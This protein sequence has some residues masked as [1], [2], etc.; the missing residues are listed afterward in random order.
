MD[1]PVG[2]S[3]SKQT[4]KSQKGSSPDNGERQGYHA[5]DVPPVGR[6]ARYSTIGLAEKL[7]LHKA[8]SAPLSGY[9]GGVDKAG[10]FVSKLQ[11]EWCDRFNVKHAVA[12]NSATSGLLAACMAIGIKPGDTVWVP[13]YTMSATAA[14]AK[15]LG[16]NIV[17][18][19]IET[20]RYSMN[21]SLF[22]QPWPKCVIV[23]NLFGHPAYLS[24]IRSWCDSN[25]VWMIEDNAQSPFA[26]ENGKYAG[27]IGHIGVFSLNVHKHVQ[28]GEGGVVTTSDSELSNRL[29]G[30]INHGELADPNLLGLNL[31]MTE[32]IAAIACA[33]LAKAEKV[34]QSR[35]DLANELTGMVRGID[36]IA[37]PQQM[38]GCRHVYYVWAAQISYGKR[39]KLVDLLT[40]KEFPA[41]KGYSKPLTHIFGGHLSGYTCPM[42]EEMERRLMIFEI[43]AYDPKSY[44]L[45]RMRD[46]IHWAAEKINED[47]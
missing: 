25:K 22:H 2:S 39:D 20:T 33:Q 1:E 45:R 9:L 31:R 41:R 32:P 34:I 21:M 23:T 7:N 24:S 18:I 37:P 15:V 36:W 6:L 13:S 12:C 3:G 30:A 27:T 46:I 11:D 29:R 40:S 16:A 35:I 10:Y 47:S 43:C 14:C 44:H 42:A 4:K 5:M 17:F 26:M 8:L 28:S 38:H 19:D